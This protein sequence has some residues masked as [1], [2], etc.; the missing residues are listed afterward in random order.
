LVKLSD[1]KLSNTSHVDTK[2][3]EAA[4]SKAHAVMLH[5][6]AATVIFCIAPIRSSASD[7][8]GTA[9]VATPSENLVNRITAE[10]D[11][12]HPKAAAMYG[13]RALKIVE[14]QSSAVTWL[15]AVQEKRGGYCTF[16]AVSESGGAPREIASF[17]GCRIHRIRFLDINQDGSMDVV[18][19]V[20][21]RGI[22]HDA[23]VGEEILFM[24]DDDGAGFCKASQSPKFAADPRALRC[25]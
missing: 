12:A 22:Q 3:R 19:S 20:D 15:L 23:R 13:R 18:Y 4:M 16:L 17:V 6:F 14:P 8:R 10:L 2:I 24:R 5:L 21:I 1:W 7:S 25:R 11:P 9:G